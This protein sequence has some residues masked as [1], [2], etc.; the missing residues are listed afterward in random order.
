MDNQAMDKM[1]RIRLTQT[2]YSGK[3]S[4]VCIPE[5]ELPKSNFPYQKLL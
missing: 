1:I 5:S 3:D 2:C 4:A